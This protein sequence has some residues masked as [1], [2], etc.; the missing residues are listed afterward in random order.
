MLLPEQVT[1]LLSF[2]RDI[3]LIK[4]KDGFGQWGAFISKINVLFYGK[5]YYPVPLLFLKGSTLS[6]G[7]LKS[8]HPPLF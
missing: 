3:S 6:E 8:W 2:S 7:V 4:W 5:A 1:S